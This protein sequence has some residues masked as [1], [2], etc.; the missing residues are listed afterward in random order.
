MRARA[1]VAVLVAAATLG[2]LTGRFVLPD[3]SSAPAAPTAS[4]SHSATAPTPA[5]G[6]VTERNLLTPTA[7][8]AVGV[9]AH[10]YVRDRFGDGRYANAECA[11]RRPS[12]RPWAG[13]ART[14]AA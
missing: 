9:T 10:L 1:V 4:P 13:R 11:G 3:R 6:P 7:F 12:A 2:V 14:S 8:A 5:T